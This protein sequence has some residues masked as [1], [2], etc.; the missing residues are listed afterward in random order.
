MRLLIDECVPEFV[1]S[2]FLGH[3]HEVFRVVEELAPGTPDNIIAQFANDQHLICVTWN[4][5]HFHALISR[6]PQ[7]NHI[8]FPHAG[9]IAFGCPEPDADRRLLQVLEIVEYEHERAQTRSDKRLIVHIMQEF[10]KVYR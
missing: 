6:K 7:N 2:V 1:T 3:Q 9:L 8:R 10:I 4:L 5:R